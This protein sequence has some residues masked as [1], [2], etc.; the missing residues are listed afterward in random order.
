MR[1]SEDRCRNRAAGRRTPLPTVSAGLFGT[2]R[3][4]VLADADAA[5]AA[6][7]DVL[8][9]ARSCLVDDLLDRLGLVLDPLLVEKHALLVEALE[10]ALDDLLDDVVGL[11]RVLRLLRVDSRLVV[12]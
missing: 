3:V 8:A 4:L 1:R 6:D 11:P 12:D 10:L 5:E 9:H 2:S 7:G